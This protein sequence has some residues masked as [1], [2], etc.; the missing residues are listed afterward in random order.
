MYKNTIHSQ[1]RA[2]QQFQRQSPLDCGPL[3]AVAVEAGFLS[4]I[5]FAGIS[6][7]EV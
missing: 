7:N 1:Q 5:D 2:G 4:E 6:M 3:P